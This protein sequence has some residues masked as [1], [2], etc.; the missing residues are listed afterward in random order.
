MLGAVDKQVRPHP[1]HPRGAVLRRGRYLP[2]GVRGVLCGCRLEH[3]GAQREV[4]RPGA[5]GARRQEGPEQP[6]ARLEAR[7][8]GRGRAGDHGRRRRARRG[9]R[10]LCAGGGRPLRGR[11]AARGLHWRRPLAA[12][13]LPRRHR[14]P[15]HGAG[16]RRHSRRARGLGGAGHA[17]R[18]RPRRECIR[19]GSGREEARGGRIHGGLR[20]ARPGRVLGGPGS[21]S[22]AGVLHDL[23]RADL[24]AAAAE[25]GGQPG[26]RGLGPQ[27]GPEPQG[28]RRLRRGA[29]RPG[30]PPGAR[31]HGLPREVRPGRAHPDVALPVGPRGAAHGAAACN[32]HSGAVRRA[33]ARARGC[34]G[35]PGA[36]GAS[37]LS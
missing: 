32:G 27:H 8:Q 24:P 31:Q 29:A 10:L 13:V 5:R 12:C 17:P 23:Q 28:L 4:P 20:R 7:L 22:A 14:R 9:F 25:Q 3:Q 26:L 37:L 15:G 2:A 11:C 16:A 19:Q 35:Q 30:R 21:E 1:A 18:L 6:G 33:S 34:R 36:G